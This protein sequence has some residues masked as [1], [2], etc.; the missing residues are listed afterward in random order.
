MP[1]LKTHAR[2]LVALLA[3]FGVAAA[4]AGPSLAGSAKT[5]KLHTAPIASLGKTVLVN[6]RGRTLYT[7]SSESRHKVNCKASCLGLWPPLKI[8]KG[9]KPV[10]AAHL[11]VMK[12]HEG[13]LQVTFKGRPLYTYS[14]DAK[15]G[16]ANGDGLPF[17]GTWHAAAVGRI[18]S[19]TPPTHTTAPEPTVPMNTTPTT[20]TPTTTTT[21]PTTT[22]Y[23]YPGY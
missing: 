7:L 15:K 21:P 22:T 9:V 3:G 17:V 11:G 8:R 1:S 10:G 6:G 20:T 4:L 2:G 12:R 5:L 16:E 13:F 19:G 14:G 18:A 23:T